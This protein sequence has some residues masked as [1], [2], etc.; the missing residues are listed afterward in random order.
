MC[1]GQSLESNKVVITQYLYDSS[2]RAVGTSLPASIG[3]ED[4]ALLF[5]RMR[6][7]QVLI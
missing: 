5:I 7:S 6:R 1:Q 4:M 2:F 3:E